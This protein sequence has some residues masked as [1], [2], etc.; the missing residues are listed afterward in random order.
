[1][2]PITQ[3]VFGTCPDLDTCQL[4]P[5]L[6]DHSPTTRSASARHGASPITTTTTTK[7]PLK[8]ALKKRPNPTDEEEQA[9]PSKQA[10]MIVTTT[11][12]TTRPKTATG[13]ASTSS[14]TAAS[15]SSQ[16]HAV[17]STS[18]ATL[19]ARKQPATKP[20]LATPSTGPPRITPYP[21]VPHTP[22]PTRQKLLNTLFE[23]FL[24]N[25]QSLSSPSI[26]ASLASKHAKEQ[27]QTLYTKST[28]M[29]YR[30]AVISALARLKKRP[31]PTSESEAGTLEDDLARQKAREEEYKGR[32]TR[33]RV[34]KFTHDVE[35]LRKF[36]YVVEVPQGVGGDRPTEEGNLR[37]CDRC[38][39]EFK[40]SNELTEAER[41]ACSYHFGKMI[42]E[43][44]RGQSWKADQTSSAWTWHGLINDFSTWDID[45]R[46]QTTCMVMLSDSRCC[47]LFSRAPCVQGESEP[48]QRLFHAGAEVRG[49]PQDSAIDVLHSRVGFLETS[50]FETTTRSCPAL[51]IVALDCELVYTTSGMSLARLTVIDATGTIILD[52]HVRPQGT[53]LDLNTRFSGVQEGDVEEA[54]LDVVGVRTA[55]GILI[56]QETI[57]VGHGLENDLKALRCVHRKVIDTAIL[58]PHPNGG[59]WRHSL[60]NLT[61]DILGRLICGLVLQFIQDSDPA[62][63]HSSVD[64]SKAAL[65]LVRWKVKEQARLGN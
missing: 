51:D 48:N 60:R 59:T 13:S 3:R 17:A 35:T 50:E 34:E 58:F 2:F 41:T 14:S 23:Q 49:N 9:L 8:S 4:R 19:N 22:V 32:L 65:E 45:H 47:D 28:K 6:F 10:K 36:D 39:T 12:T 54:S 63:G 52:E 29:T 5:C 1:M 57:I 26:A 30:N 21:G 16:G 11:T 64:D 53:V 38:G 44:H 46:Y 55:L 37:R 40:V 33:E 20:L 24:L 43:K 18:R 15:T 62:L 27:E 61:K 25:Y 42:T 7:L 31:L 56:D